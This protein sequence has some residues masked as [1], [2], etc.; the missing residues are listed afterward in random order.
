MCAAECFG[1]SCKT[2]L[3]V[4]PLNSIYTFNNVKTKYNLLLYP[5]IG[6]TNAAYF[7]RKILTKLEQHFYTAQRKVTTQLV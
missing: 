3:F 4:K 2:E 6:G 5:E 7:V 1:I